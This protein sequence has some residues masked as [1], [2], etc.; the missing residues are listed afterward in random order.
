LLDDGRELAFDAA[1]FDAGGMRLARFGQRVRIRVDGGSSD[2]RVTAL[3][4]AT[5]PDF[6]EP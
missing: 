6:P 5:F 3:T 2:Q 4:L 1:A